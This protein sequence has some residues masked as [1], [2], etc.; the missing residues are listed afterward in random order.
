MSHPIL[1]TGASG[2]P[3]ATGRNP[4]TLEEFFRENAASVG[5][6]KY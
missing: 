1:I 2:G 3:Q 6:K 5:A 4:Q